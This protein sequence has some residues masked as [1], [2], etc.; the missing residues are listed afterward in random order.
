MPVQILN[1]HNNTLELLPQKAIFWHDTQTLIVSDLHLGKASHFRKHGMAIPMES[2]TDDLEQLDILLSKYKPKRLLI[3]GDL[4]HS[5]YNQEWE[6]FGTLRRKYENI[7][8]VLVRGN[9]DILIEHEY[10]KFDIQ[11]ETEPIS[12]NGFVFAHNF[13]MLKE[14]EFSISGHIHPGFVLHGKGRQS[15]TL[16]CFY[17]KQNTLIMPAFGRLTGLAHMPYDKDAEVFVLTEDAVHRI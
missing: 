13:V 6:Y 9:H 10:E 4:F 11:V 12:E 16:P 3:L 17:K 2:G 5:E 8:F 14:N 15:I 1:I 7:K